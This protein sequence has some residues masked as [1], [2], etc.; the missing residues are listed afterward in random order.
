M[1]C[2]L[3]VAAKAGEVRG[4]AQYGYRAFSRALEAIPLALAANSGLDAISAVDELRRAQ[5][6]T[7]AL[8]INGASFS[9]STLGINGISC[10]PSDM[11]EEG[12]FETLI[13]KRQQL[14]L[15][16]QLAKMVLK[17]DDVIE[18]DDIDYE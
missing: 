11:R 12:V 3:E 5:A 14:Q 16:T 4:L 13:G 2:S 7:P 17:T 8:S 9:T 18:G 1:S 15:A 6:G 10:T